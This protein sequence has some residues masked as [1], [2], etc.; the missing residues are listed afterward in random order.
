VLKKALKTTSS[1]HADQI[2]PAGTLAEAANSNESLEG[3]AAMNGLNE[4]DEIARLAHSFAEQ[5]SREGRDGNADEDWY[6]AEREIRTRRD[7][8]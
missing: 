3:Y 4:D 6:R 2:E 5:R 1:A 7:P 8:R